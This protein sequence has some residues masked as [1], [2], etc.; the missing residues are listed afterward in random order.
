LM[1]REDSMENRISEK[2]DNYDPVAEVYAAAF[3]NELSDK[4]LD[5]GY[6]DMFRELVGTDGLVCDLGCGPGQIA[7]YLKS[8][9]MNVI[10]V[11]KS[12]GMVEVASRFN[13]DLDFYCDDMSSLQVGN[14][15][16]AGIVN[17]YAII[18][19]PP[20][21]ILKVLQEWNRVLESGGILLMSYLVGEEIRYVSE[22]LDKEVDL[23]FN[24]YPR[25]YMKNALGEAGFELIA[26]MEREPYSGVEYQGRRGYFIAK[27]KN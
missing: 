2:K 18:H 17:F 5:R 14:S 9:D 7:R 16:W 15:S 4:P 20:K 21:E 6:L 24:L 3:L 1:K 22:L 10:G 11:D 25:E 12:K 27:K 23:E 19:V 13:P 8:L 26:S